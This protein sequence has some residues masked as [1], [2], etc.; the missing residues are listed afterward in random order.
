MRQAASN[1]S[2]AGVARD[3]ARGLLA[4]RAVEIRPDNPFLWAS[5]WHSPMYCDNRLI[6]SHPVLREQVLRGLTQLL[7]ER[8]PGV[9]L[10][11]GCATAGIPHAA[12]LADRLHLPLVYVRSKAKDHGKGRRVEGRVLP[13][14]RVVV[15]EDTL[16]TGGSAFDAAEAVRAE[17][18]DVIGVLAVFS[19]EFDRMRERSAASGIPAWAL[20]DYETLIQAAVETGYV[21]E[22]QVSLLREWR[23]AP[24]QWSGAPS[25]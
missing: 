6:W 5:G 21:R 17:G 10:L 24:D 15:V 2:V 18:G 16:S 19:Y 23:R 25:R 22:D 3:V 4:V 8:A 11:A 20:V 12:M 1:A 7:M 9:E 13:G 14:Q